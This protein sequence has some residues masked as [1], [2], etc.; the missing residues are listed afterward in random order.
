MAKRKNGKRDESL[1]LQSTLQ[2]TVRDLRRAYKKDDPFLTMA[3]INARRQFLNTK[4]AVKEHNPSRMDHW[5]GH[6]L[7][8]KPNK[9]GQ[10]KVKGY[11]NH[12]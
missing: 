9:Y 2:A 11:C 1:G 3:I 7:A 6:A 10:I 8:T 4:R 5:V 12:R